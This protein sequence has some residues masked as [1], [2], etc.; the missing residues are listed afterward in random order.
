MSTS[1]YI[2]VYKKISAHDGTT[3]VYTYLD[4]HIHIY[5]HIYI[6]TYI[7]TYIQYIHT[8]IM[9]ISGGC[10]W[11]W[12]T[13]LLTLYYWSWKKI[14]HQLVNIDSLSQYLQ[15]FIHPRWC[16]ISSINSMNTHFATKNLNWK[17]HLECWSVLF[18]VDLLAGNLSVHVTYLY[19]VYLGK[20]QY[21]LNLNSGIPLLFTNL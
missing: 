13:F 21:F 17:V 14:L 6:Y 18:D 11:M 9:R 19:S 4:V 3:C 16:R 2:L 20:L 7:H 15:S 8:Y 5:S 12:R 1:W 10:V